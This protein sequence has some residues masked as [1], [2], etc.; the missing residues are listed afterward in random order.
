MGGVQQTRFKKCEICGEDYDTKNNQNRKTCSIKCSLKMRT[1]KVI[2]VCPNCNENFSIKRSEI[3]TTKN[4]CSR[5]CYNTFKRNNPS[6]TTLIK[7]RTKSVWTLLNLRCSNG[8]YHNM[9]TKDKCKVY[10]NILLFFSRDELEKFIT[11]N[12]EYI[13]NLN[14]PSIDRIDSS[15]HYSLENIR[16]IELID[17]IRRK[18]YNRYNK[19]NRNV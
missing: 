3:N 5:N 2:L 4:F 7:R 14:R 1:K 8:K 12:W 10:E 17:N 11:D 18:R 19:E 6:E 13:K 9:R 16:F 15:G